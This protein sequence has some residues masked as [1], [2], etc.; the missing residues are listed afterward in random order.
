MTKS[1]TLLLVA[2]L[3]LAGVGMSASQAQQG[4]SGAALAEP[5][6]GLF[7]PD[8]PG[9]PAK[10]RKAKKAK[11]AKAT[12]PRE[13]AQ[14]ATGKKDNRKKDDK[15]GASLERAP[16]TEEDRYSAI[17][18]GLPGIRFWADSLG[19]FMDTLPR[20]KGPWLILSSGGSAGA[21]G[22]GV[23]YGLS[24]A[25]KRPDFTVVTGVSIGAVMAPYAFLG[26]KYDEQ[27]RE[28][29]LSLTS[30]DVFEDTQ[31]PD[32]L[33]D[34]WPLKD[35]L[36]KRVTLQ[37]LADVAVEHRKGRRLYVVTADLDAERAV[38]WN[39]GAIAAH[40]GEA[41]ANLFR[42]ILL[43]ASAIPGVFP[44]AYIDVEANGKKFQE[45]HVDGGV[46]GPFYAAPSS[47]LVDPESELPVTQ[48]YVIVHSKLA[49][50]FD[51][52]G[53][54]KIFILGRTISAAIKAGAQAQIALLSAATKRHDI[55]LNVTYIDNS[56]NVKAETSF[57]P[58]Q[59]KALF[60]FGVE[61]AKNGTAFRTQNAAPAGQVQKRD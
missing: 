11:P 5:C 40:G 15:K 13:T 60:D 6:R 29:F 54:E 22:A 9:A 49:P 47:W 39:M 36:A 17:V 33:V 55:G 51:V 27:L 50:E 26:Q 21:Y 59:M 44:P 38:L 61:Q 20:E 23:L 3:V 57:D 7:C 10:V 52:T 12:K 34:T 2:T 25:G 46:V 56:F 35:F 4:A 8:P 32:S 37:L 31:R 43:A 58:K 48:M 19:A 16:F 53:K 45:M 1:G 24:Q 41:A 28:S 18:P 42:Q 30:A 14:A